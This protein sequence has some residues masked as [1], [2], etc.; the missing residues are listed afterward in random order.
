M[1]REPTKRTAA[2]GEVVEVGI[3]GCDA[4]NPRRGLPDDAE[5]L[6]R[7]ML[8]ILVAFNR[9]TPQQLQEALGL[10]PELI[11]AMRS[12]PDVVELIRDLRALLP[13]P[14]DV[15]ELLM[16]DAERNIRWLRKLREGRFDHI[17]PKLLRVRGRAAEVLLD[18]QVPKKVAVALD[19][20]RTIDVTPAQVERMRALLGGDP[21]DGDEVVPTA[22]AEDV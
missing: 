11:E 5:S 13:R 1:K 15:N 22:P 10:T 6:R 12:D 4:V 19:V 21:T 16:S 8:T 18:R 3:R 9:F 2:N 17:D 20:T 14:G 7:E